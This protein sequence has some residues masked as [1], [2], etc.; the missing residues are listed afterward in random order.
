M[1]AMSPLP[2]MSW[3][4]WQLYVL[5]LQDLDFE[6]HCVEIARIDSAAGPT[7]KAMDSLG[8]GGVNVAVGVPPAVGSDSNPVLK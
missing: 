7:Y 5:P 3:P 1:A 6:P 2:G 4:A 8:A